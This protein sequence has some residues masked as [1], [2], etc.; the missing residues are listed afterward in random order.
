MKVHAASLWETHVPEAKWE[1]G[2]EIC[3]CL[4]FHYQLLCDAG[5]A[6]T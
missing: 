5:T 1:V 4:S 2:I 6:Q 3:D